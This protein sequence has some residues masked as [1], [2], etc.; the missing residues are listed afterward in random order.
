MDIDIKKIK[1]LAELAKANDLAK[2]KVTDGDKSVVIETTVETV[3]QT[4]A[5]PVA[6]APAM[7]APVSAPS[8]ATAA[9]AAAST[10]AANDSAHAITSPMVGTFYSSPS[11]DADAFV[12]VG[13]KVSKGQTL[14]IIE[15]MKLMNELESDADGTVVE[16]LGQN[17]QPVE[18]GQTLFRIQA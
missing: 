4:I 9:P 3:V 13:D 10:P 6:A 2:I 15:A 17:G 8:S 16:I 11:P 1:E 14:C 12:K 7:A 18:F 5:A